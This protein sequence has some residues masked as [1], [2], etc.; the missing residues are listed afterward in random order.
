MQLTVSTDVES[1]RYKQKD[2]KTPGASVSTG[3]SEVASIW[4]RIRDECRLS[5]KKKCSCLYG[6]LD[7]HPGGR[8]EDSGI[9]GTRQ[10]G[11][12][13]HSIEIT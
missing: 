1:S 10:S 4:Q 9:S 11:T 5:F 7:H 2:D 3:P 6:W 8:A 13:G 12:H